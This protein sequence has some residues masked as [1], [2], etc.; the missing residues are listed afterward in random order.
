MEDEII[1]YLKDKRGRKISISSLKH[2]LRIKGEE[3]LELF[4]KTISTLEESSKIINLNDEVMIFPR[5]SCYVEGHLRVKKSGNAYVGDYLIPKELTNG[6]LNGDLVLIATSNKMYYDKTL[7]MVKKII[8][9]KKDII[10]CIYLNNKLV[11][12]EE[13][14]FINLSVPESDLSKL[15]NGEVVQVRIDS[16]IQDNIIYGRIINTTLDKNEPNYAEKLIALNHGFALDFS[17]EALKEADM[18]SE[19]IKDE[20]I[21]DR[22]DLRDEL[23]FT[24]DGDNTKD[25]DDAV[26]IK[27]LDN[28]N[29]L[30]G[31]H[32]AHVSHYVKRNSTLFKEAEERATSLYLNNSVIPMLPKRLSN[33]ICS[34]NEGVDRLT[35]STLMEID[36][37]GKIISFKIVP[38]I[39]NSRAKLKYSTVNK[40]LEENEN[41]ISD[42]EIVHSLKTWPT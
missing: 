29:F 7:A 36:R 15:T 27:I 10:N 35:M 2:A 41:V 38:S 34:L 13:N 39:I 8:K 22:L 3:Q 33:N 28:Q 21:K 19:E 18:I 4:N 24:I 32:I 17:D 37:N 14:T 11:P 23:V 6:A 9:R 31:V 20:E 30:L 1:N 40:L 16:S 26:S 42:Q 12:C 25:M 5:H